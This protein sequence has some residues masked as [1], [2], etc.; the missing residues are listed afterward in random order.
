MVKKRFNPN[1]AELLYSE[2][3]RA[4]LPV[5]EVIQH[6][7]LSNEDTVADLGAGNGYFTLPVAK[8]LKATSMRWILS[9][10]C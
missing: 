5:E 3:R 10:K 2:E 8:K 4:M 6:L 9:Q 7:N 1:K